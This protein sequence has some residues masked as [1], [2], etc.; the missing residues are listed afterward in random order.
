M[1]ASDVFSISCSNY[2][3]ATLQLF[4]VNSYYLKVTDVIFA[5]LYMKLNYVKCMLKICMSQV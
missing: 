1:S 2:V 3:N 5:N 4:D